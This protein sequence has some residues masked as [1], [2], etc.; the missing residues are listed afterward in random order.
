MG[1]HFFIIGQIDD[2]AQRIDDARLIGL[3][4]IVNTALEGLAGAAQRVGATSDPARRRL[5]RNEGV[6]KGYRVGIT[7]APGS[8]VVT[9]I[10]LQLR[11]GL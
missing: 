10:A 1:Q 9:P 11:Q 6:G 3:V 5:T 7:P 4:E 2:H 8:G